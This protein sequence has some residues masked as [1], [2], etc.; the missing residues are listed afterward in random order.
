MF[1][2]PC[3]L[4]LLHLRRLNTSFDKTTPAAS[5]AAAAAAMFNSVDLTTVGGEQQ[6]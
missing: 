5:P 4:P 3:P 1:S 6:N 2:V